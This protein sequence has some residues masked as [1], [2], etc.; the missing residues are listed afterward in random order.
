[1]MNQRKRSGAQGWNRSTTSGD[2]LEQKRTILAM[3]SKGLP[4]RFL[5]LRE[6]G[7]DGE[8]EGQDYGEWRGL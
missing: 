2:G 6:Q 1:M 3:E 4:R 8:H 7:D 5:R